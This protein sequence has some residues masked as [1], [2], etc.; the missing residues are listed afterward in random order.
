[1]RGAAALGVA[2]G[3]GVLLDACG[4]SSS[5]LSTA[6]GKV[7][8]GG[9][10]V[11]ARTQGAE[12]LNP[13]L[14]ADN[15]SIWTIT[16]IFDQ[17]LEAR[18][19]Y[20]DPQPGL[21][22]SWTMSDGG[23]TYTFL[24]RDAAFSDGSPVTADD[25]KFTLDRFANP[26]INS[27]YSFLGSSIASTT[28]VNSRTVAVHLKHVDSTF[29]F[30]LAMFVPSVVPQKA[31]TEMGEE[32]FGR[33][34]IGSGA[35]RVK[36]WTP[37][38][39]L[40]LERNPHYWRSGRPYLD[41]VTF[42]YVADDNTRML[43]LQSGEADIADEIPYPDISRLDKQS[44]ITVLSES[45]STWNCITLNNAVAP[46]ND[47]AVRQ[48][49]N[50]ATP[51][52]HILDTVYLGRAELANSQVGK[53]KYW[54]PSIKTYDYDPGRARDLIKGSSASGGFTVPVI[55]VSEDSVELE[56]AE[57]IQAAWAELGIKM[58]IDQ[59][60]IGTALTQWYA[61]QK[62]AM[63]FPDNALSSDTL[64]SGENDAIFLDYSEGFNSFFTN[65]KS[66]A[67]ANLVN[68]IV[69]TLDQARQTQLYSQLQTLGMQDTPSIALFFTYA[70]TG[71]STNVH[72]FATVPTGWW[73]LDEVWLG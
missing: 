3:S 4:K 49:L 53:V 40:E 37:G 52:Q 66:A 67:A 65:Y 58:S 70:C 20:A 31:V 29:L 47:P 10:L 36:S 39:T 72:G 35:F 14:A 22:E 24:L 51:R 62:P 26:K 16:Q 69:G 63:L 11:F 15:G 64:S 68:E 25:V 2:L 60:D 34:P 9:T 1:M 73:N 17:I 46:F 38:V 61:D 5:S 33:S 59:V 23:L 42:N 13:M 19:G 32:A 43:S 45:I 44:G 27:N 8:S 12:T 55:T 18:H 6:A 7:K 71:I 57:I 54:D 48:A 41:G 21:A 30:N 50:Y 56:T 28:V